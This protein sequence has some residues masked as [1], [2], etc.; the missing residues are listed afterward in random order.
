MLHSIIYVYSTN[1]NTILVR[2]SYNNSPTHKATHVHK[3]QRLKTT[4]VAFSLMLHFPC[5]GDS[6]P[7]QASWVDQWLKKINK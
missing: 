7:S 1:I 2:I 5:A 3:S 6:I 4:K